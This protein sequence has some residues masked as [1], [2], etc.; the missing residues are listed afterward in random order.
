MIRRPPRSTHCISSAA[1][2]VYK[3]QIFFILVFQ[4]I[5][6]I[7][8]VSHCWIC[9]PIRQELEQYCN[10]FISLQCYTVASSADNIIILH[11]LIVHLI[12]PESPFIRISNQLKFLVLTT[13]L[14]IRILYCYFVCLFLRFFAL[15]FVW[16]DFYFTE[17]YRFYSFF[18]KK[19]RENV[20][21]QCCFFFVPYTN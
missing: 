7:F 9:F 4:Y 5:L 12:Y 11:W 3:R 17:K 10:R 20:F 13:V 21:N 8:I 2:D 14:G 18:T 15:E 16:N 6:Y 19:F 1:S